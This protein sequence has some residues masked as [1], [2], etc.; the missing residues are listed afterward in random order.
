VLNV[1]FPAPNDFHGAVNVLR[2]AN[3]KNTAIGFEPAPEAP[4]Q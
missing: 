1:F 3:G 4:A 2:D